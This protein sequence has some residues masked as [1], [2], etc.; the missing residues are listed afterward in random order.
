MQVLQYKS[1]ETSR[2]L[3]QLTNSLRIF[4]L[5]PFYFV[6]GTIIVRFAFSYHRVTSRPKFKQKRT[7]TSRRKMMK[8][9]TLLWKKNRRQKMEQRQSK[10]L[11]KTVKRRQK[12]NTREV[13][14]GNQKYLRVK[15][16]PKA[17]LKKERLINQMRSLR[18]VKE[19]AWLVCLVM[20]MK[21]KK[22]KRRVMKHS[23]SNS[24]QFLDSRS[25]SISIS[26]C[27]ITWKRKKEKLFQNHSLLCPLLGIPAVDCNFSCFLGVKSA[28]VIR[29]LFCAH[30]S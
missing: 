2:N 8:T 4:F 16:R 1:P 29:D 15:R 17:T 19:R 27:Q 14:I 20:L 7:K 3:E 18:H 26:N 9:L 30:A 12:W 6:F 13:V 21:I 5:L 24:G 28:K 23:H 11:R 22:M 10:N 25:V